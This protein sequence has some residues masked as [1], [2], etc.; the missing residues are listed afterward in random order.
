MFSIERLLSTVRCT[1]GGREEP[2]PLP[3][4][5]ES[6]KGDVIGIDTFV[7]CDKDSIELSSD[8]VSSPPACDDLESSDKE[9][10]K[11]KTKRSRTTFTSFQLEELELIFRQTHYPDV[12]L[13][14]KLATKIGLPESRVQVWFQNRRAKWR[15]REKMITA[16]KDAKLFHIMNGT[17]TRDYPMP[18]NPLATWPWNR[19]LARPPV[20]RPLYSFPTSPPVYPTSPGAWQAQY[21]QTSFVPLRMSHAQPGWI[22][23]PNTP[24]LPFISSPSISGHLPP[25]MLQPPAKSD[26]L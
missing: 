10:N 24:S 13:R 22:T 21:D 2:V 3:S 15:K 5:G 20:F 23:S 1:P 16:S 12:L 6:K 17:N 7:E 11:C 14:E 9:A 4:E 18:A 25:N 19:Q 8:E 26:I